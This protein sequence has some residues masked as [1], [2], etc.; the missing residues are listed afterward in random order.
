MKD[1]IHTRQVITTTCL[2]CI[3]STVCRKQYACNRLT[4]N[5]DYCF[6]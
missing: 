2:Y 5:V 1:E 6:C 4:K 3:V